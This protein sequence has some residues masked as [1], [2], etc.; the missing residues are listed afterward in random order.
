MKRKLDTEDVPTVI[1]VPTA[2]ESSDAEANFGTLSLD[3]RLLQAIAKEGFA[4]PTPV[5]VRAIPLALEGRDILGMA[6]RHL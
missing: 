6:I 3:H 4:K 2:S 1:A 5:Q